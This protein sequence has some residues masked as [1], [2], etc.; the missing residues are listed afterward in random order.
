MV[1]VDE[2]NIWVNVG[3]RIFKL[4]IAQ[5]VPKFDDE[6][7]NDNVMILIRSLAQFVTI[8]MPGICITKQMYRCMHKCVQTNFENTEVKEIKA[9]MS[10]GTFMIV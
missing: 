3:K 4:S 8:E 10:E 6:M 1:D 5:A 7:K 2:K 9:L